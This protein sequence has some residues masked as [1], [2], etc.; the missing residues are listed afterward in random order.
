MS[1]SDVKAEETPVP[2]EYS[3]YNWADWGCDSVVLIFLGLSRIR[4]WSSGAY[5]RTARRVLI[6][7]SDDKGLAPAGG[8]ALTWAAWQALTLPPPSRLPVITHRE[9]GN[10]AGRE[11]CWPAVTFVPVHSV[12]SRITA[13]QPQKAVTT[14]L[15]S[16]HSL[17]LVF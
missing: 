3:S 17:P 11:S 9:Q 2:R 7:I 16:N 10:P 6:I 4:S 8:Q 1:D 15:K 14:Y 5:W 13:L 12:C